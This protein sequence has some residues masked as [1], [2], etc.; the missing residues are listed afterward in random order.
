MSDAHF[1]GHARTE[2]GLDRRSRQDALRRLERIHPARKRR[3]EA[4]EGVGL[5][6]EL[7]V[8]VDELQLVRADARILGQLL[9]EAGHV[10]VVRAGAGHVV[11]ETGGVEAVAYQSVIRQRHGVE[12]RAGDRVESVE[13]AYLK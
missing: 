4:I 9:I 1:I 3:F 10:L 11:A 5:E 13:D 7:G 2:S 8:V 6:Q 12:L